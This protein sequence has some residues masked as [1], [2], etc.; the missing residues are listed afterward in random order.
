MRFLPRLQSASKDVYLILLYGKSGLIK[1]MLVHL[2]RSATMRRTVP[3]SDV[4]AWPFLLPGNLACRAL[5]LAKHHDLVR[6]LFW[7][8]LGVLIVVFAT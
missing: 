8:V 2:F 3:I 5:G 6:M 7:T 4:V 1:S